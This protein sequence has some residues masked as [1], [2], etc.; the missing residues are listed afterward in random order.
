MVTWLVTKNELFTFHDRGYDVASE[1]EAAEFSLFFLRDVLTCIWPT[2]HLVPMVKRFCLAI[3][4]N[5]CTWW[6]WILVCAFGYI[7]SCNIYTFVIN[8]VSTATY[9]GCVFSFWN[10]EMCDECNICLNVMDK[11]F[12]S[13]KWNCLRLES[14]TDGYK[15]FHY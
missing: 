3:V 1:R 5:M 2:S 13:T 6:M 8:Y 12:L 10:P 15:T 7:L 11:A 4:E 9:V 14:K